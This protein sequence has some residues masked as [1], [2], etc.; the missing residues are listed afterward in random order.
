[1]SKSS[2]KTRRKPVGQ[3]HSIIW[4]IAG[5]VFLLISIT[6]IVV[7]IPSFIENA[8]NLKEIGL[9]KYVRDLALFTGFCALFGFSGYGL[10]RGGIK[11]SNE[12][13]AFEK[14]NT[15]TDAKVLKR[16]KRLH[17]SENP[18]LDTGDQV[19]L[20]IVVQFETESGSLSL[21]AEVSKKLYDQ[22]SL[23]EIISVK[24]TNSNPRIA[25]LEGEF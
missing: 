14:G 18:Y 3:V 12:K 11:T 22:I 2:I 25:L 9:G 23:H 17:K 5:I 21:K 1:M 15:I 7:S 24:Y 10:I 6:C 8:S 20:Y 13:N 19:H 16:Y 4:A